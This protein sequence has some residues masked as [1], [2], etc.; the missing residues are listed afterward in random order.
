MHRSTKKLITCIALTL[1]LTLPL[2]K[3]QAKGI[4]SQRNS[5]RSSSDIQSNK[6]SDLFY[7]ASTK[8]RQDLNKAQQLFNASSF[9][10]SAIY[11]T[12]VISSTT[13]QALKNE[14]LTGRAQTYIILKQ[15]L[16]SIKDLQETSFS[17][18]EQKAKARK[19]LILGVAYIQAKLYQ[20]AIN[21]LNA[22]S[23]ILTGEA[24]LYSN[25]AVAYQNLGKI[26][27]AKA[28]LYKALKLNPTPSTILNLAVIERKSKNYKLCLSILDK[29]TGDTQNYS[30]I[31]LERGSC[32]K[33]LGNAELA[34][35]NF[36]KAIELEGPT[37]FAL[38]KIGE[39]LISKGD[40]KNGV[41]YLEK[42]SEILLQNGEIEKYGQLINTIQKTKG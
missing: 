31:F 42:A 10:E 16:L 36:L 38:Q 30:R 39:I 41:V 9:T 14:A 7:L 15:P 8:V 37:S 20:S 24:T 35:E 18:N 32:L 19:D 6:N 22:A 23:K 4:N 21:S 12:R 13:N 29:L 5:S 34:L 27:L 26:K 40:T 25:R 11:F 33:S 3:A 17:R 1:P 28:D 2:D